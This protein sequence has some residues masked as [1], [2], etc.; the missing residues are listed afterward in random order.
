MYRGGVLTSEEVT[1]K[2]EYQIARLILALVYFFV[3]ASFVNVD[4]LVALKLDA[5]RR[6]YKPPS[7][8]CISHLASGLFKHRKVNTAE[9]RR[10]VSHGNKLEFKAEFIVDF[11]EFGRKSKADCGF[12]KNTFRIADAL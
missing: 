1:P 11:D 2:K 4:I 6:L 9:E 12:D 7:A 5:I 3:E 8:S 10:S